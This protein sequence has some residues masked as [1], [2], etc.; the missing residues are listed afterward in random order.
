L[1]LG[2]FLLYRSR[3][4]GPA[5]RV[6]SFGIFW[7]FITL[8]VESSFIPIRDVIFEYRVY[9][10]SVGATMAVAAGAAI[11][12]HRLR[13]RRLMVAATALIV[14]VPLVLTAAAYRRNAVWQSYVTLWEDVVRKAPGNVRGHYNTGVAY[15]DRGLMDK[16]IE[17]YRSAIR[18]K[19]SGGPY[20]PEAHNGLGNAYAAQGLHKEAIEHFRAAIALAPGYAAAH[21]NLGCLYGS[22]GQLEKAEEHLR[23][24]I[25]L[26]PDY[27]H[28]YNNLGNVYFLSGKYDEA[29]KHFQF[30]LKNNQENYEARYNLGL[31]Y[32]EKGLEAKAQEH[33]RI[34]ESLRQKG[35]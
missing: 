25:K 32:R 26:Q 24:A 3:T 27:S 17:R 6:I 8:S 29:I 2:A 22:I 21:Y 30:A 19:P 34:A 18:L 16:A 5:S 31:A 9:L 35:R 14:I 13:D 28:A 1:G 10:P 20:I 15:E 11:A 4:S 7:F 23:A 33:F 12:L